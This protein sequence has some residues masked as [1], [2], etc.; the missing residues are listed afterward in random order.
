MAEERGHETFVEEPG[1]P[2]ASSV[3]P[4]VAEL[5]KSNKNKKK[6]SLPGVPLPHH[7]QWFHLKLAH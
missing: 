1:L 5:G 6:V 7:N 4:P 3:F 2:T